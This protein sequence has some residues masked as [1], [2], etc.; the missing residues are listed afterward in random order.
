[1]RIGWRPGMTHP[2]STSSGT[3][4]KL[5][6]TDGGILWYHTRQQGEDAQSVT[7][8]WDEYPFLYLAEYILPDTLE[9]EYEPIIR[10]ILSFTEFG[11]IRSMYEARDLVTAQFDDAVASAGFCDFDLSTGAWCIFVD[12]TE[13]T[14]RRYFHVPEDG[15]IREYFSE[16]QP[17]GGSEIVFR[18]S[19]E[20]P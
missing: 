11:G 2:D 20:T 15:D 9:A 3:Q 1:M 12:E 10:E 7:V 18:E 8:S 6:L 13:D 5:P 4:T 16:D 14:P 19:E 17:L